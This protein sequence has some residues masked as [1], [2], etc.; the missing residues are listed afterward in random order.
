MT[1]RTFGFPGRYV[2]GP[3]ALKEIG[4]TARELG[5]TSV[6]VVADPQLTEAIEVVRLSLAAAELPARVIHSPA[7]CTEAGA[8]ALVDE[9]GE[10]DCVV[11]FGG[12]KTIDLSKAVSRST[13]ARLVIA[14][15]IASND[16]PTS[17][18]IV[19]YN[20]QHKVDR[21]LLTRHNPDV[22]LVDTEVIA[23]APARFLAAGMADALSKKF[24]VGQC[25][26][27]GGTNFFGTRPLSTALFLA[28]QA[29]RVILTHGRGAMAAVE[30]KTVSNDLE[31]VVEAAVL[32]SG[33]AFES[34]GLSLAHALLRGLTA[35]PS[36]APFLHG[37]LVAYGTLVQM[38]YEGRSD[39]EIAEQ[40][41]FYEVLGLP[42]SLGDITTGVIGDREQRLVAR[43]TCEAPYIGN[44][45]KP[46][47]EAS[48]LAAMIAVENRRGV[49]RQAEADE[50]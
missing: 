45:I 39:A 33:L 10:F 4:A 48:V 42:R 9:A 46:A 2:Q 35:L 40:S 1:L 32:L 30:A 16:A 13:G 22:V 20:D 27:A 28:D 25:A 47:S 15:S 29:H 21:V 14:P 31:N 18:L 19:L 12:G 38:A 37:E 50:R 43:L 5:A 23:R 11:G 34:G 26:A 44:L 49:N 36:C 8:Q 24:E 3:G 7:E 6:V 17:R 41:A